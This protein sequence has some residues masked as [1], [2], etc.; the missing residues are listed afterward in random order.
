MQQKPNGEPEQEPTDKNVKN[1]PSADFA[2]LIDAITAEGR[3]YRAEEK[4]EDK[5]KGF[6]EWI[7]IILLGATM[8]G[9]FWQVYE[10]VHVY[11]P[12]RD[13]AEAS[14]KSADAAAKQ[15]ESSDRALMEAQRA[16]VGPRTASFTAEPAIG[17]PIEIAIEYQNTGREPALGFI[18]MADSFSISAKEA[19]SG[20]GRIKDY[21]AACKNVKDWNGG[22]V[23]YPG[24]S[25]FSTGY[26]FFSKTKENFVDDAIVKGKKV[27]ILQG[28]F[29]YRTFNLPRHSYFCYFYKQGFTKIQNLNICQSGHDA[30]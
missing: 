16:W 2:A 20:I 17:K 24:T 19:D 1:R 8:A 13:Q 25:G 18:Y 14:K 21:M 27:I 23:V 5:G 11:G 9:I 28:C 30:N 26:T 6:R 29:L 10:M 3:A 12:I 22:S 7:T 15:A 4:R